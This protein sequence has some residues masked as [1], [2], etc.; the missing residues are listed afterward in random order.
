M[1]FNPISSFCIVCLYVF[2]LMSR[3]MH[4]LFYPRQLHF[5][6]I[7]LSSIAYIN[8]DIISALK[9]LAF[10]LGIQDI[11]LL[12]EGAPAYNSFMK[13]LFYERPW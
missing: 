9:D 2:S 5:P 10:Y 12:G 11:C 6:D 7:I 8:K 3:L 4:S 1:K 13:C